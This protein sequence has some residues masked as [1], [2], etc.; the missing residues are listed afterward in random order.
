MASQKEVISVRITRNVHALLSK[1]EVLRAALKATLGGDQTL[2]HRVVG[3]I[4]V[5]DNVVRILRFPQ[6]YGGRIP[7]HRI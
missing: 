5:H 6:R 3:Q 1:A 2:H 7:P 4:Q